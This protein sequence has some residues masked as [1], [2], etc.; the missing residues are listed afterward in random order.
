MWCS[1]FCSRFS[2][3]CSWVY[4]Q[5]AHLPCSSTI[6][7]HWLHLTFHQSAQWKIT[8]NTYIWVSLRSTWMLR[9]LKHFKKSSNMFF[10]CITNHYMKKSSVSVVS[11]IVQSRQDNDNQ[12]NLWGQMSIVKVQARARASKTHSWHSSH[13]INGVH[14]S[15]TVDINSSFNHR[16]PHWNTTEHVQ[17]HLNG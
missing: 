9:F 10:Y 5:Q 13:H 6:T 14:W 3:H 8:D 15:N 4:S 2:W 17:Q 11:G 16:W 7:P 1:W 12:A